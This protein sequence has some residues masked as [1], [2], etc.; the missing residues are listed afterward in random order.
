MGL[1]D[2]N[3]KVI[4]KSKPFIL[5]FC[6]CG[7]GE[8][9]NIRDKRG[10]LRRYVYGHQSRGIM[11]KD[12]KGWYIDSRGYKSLYMPEYPNCDKRGRIL[13]HRYIM[14]QHIGRHLTK[15]EIIHHRDGNKLNNDISNL[16][17]TKRGKHQQDY[18]SKDMS[19]RS[20]KICGLDKTGKQTNG[21][22]HW[23]GNEKDGFMC[24]KC[25]DSKRFQE[26]KD[27]VSKLDYICLLCNSTETHY[28][29]Y[30]Y[31]NG[32]ICSKCYLCLWKQKNQRAASGG[33]T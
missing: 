1:E 5:G 3:V 22:P 23:N 4:K 27:R 8:E 30:N 17:I 16:V 24:D 10:R 9:I 20:C 28:I 2:R 18:H 11:R 26:K 31:E 6:A 12:R 21:K 7:C 32:K 19:N 15:V 29:W 33:A 25:Y 14:E 13:E